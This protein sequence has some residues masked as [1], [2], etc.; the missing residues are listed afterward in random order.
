MPGPYSEDEEKAL[1]VIEDQLMAAQVSSARMMKMY[2]EFLRKCILARHFDSTVPSMQLVFIS[3]HL[4][5]AISSFGTDSG[6]ELRR[7]SRRELW[8]LSDRFEKE[9]PTLAALSRCAVCCCSEEGEWNPENSESLT[10]IPFYLFLLKRLDSNMGLE[11]LR[12]A[13]VHLLDFA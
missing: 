1:D 8:F 7:S 10:P 13:R 9:N 2:A 12:Y 3:K 4:L 11:F 6:D 5:T